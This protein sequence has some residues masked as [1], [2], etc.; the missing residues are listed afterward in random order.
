MIY[1]YEGPDGCGKTTKAFQFCKGNLGYTYI[2][3]KEIPKDEEIAS[4]LSSNE[5][6]IIRGS[7]DIILDRSFII[8]EF[9]YSRALNRESYVTEAMLSDF[10]FFLKLVKA[11]MCFYS[12]KDEPS[13][14]NP[15]DKS[16]PLFKIKS[17]YDDIYNQC[18]DIHL[19]ASIDYIEEIRNAD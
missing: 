19:G 16:L 7:E 6:R 5:V 9:V 15:A 13:I 10:L 12:F 17:I 14:V 8:S 1:I 4:F 3:N 2:H 18:I 11:R